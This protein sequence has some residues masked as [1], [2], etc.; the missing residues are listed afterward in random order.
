MRQ[1]AYS[2]QAYARRNALNRFLYRWLCDYVL[3]ALERTIAQL[4]GAT[5]DGR[6]RTQ[7]TCFL[8]SAS[9][10]PEADP[11]QVCSCVVVVNNR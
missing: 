11:L 5:D 7:R 9:L 3:R 4:A 8:L 10:D 2:E 6:S 1:I